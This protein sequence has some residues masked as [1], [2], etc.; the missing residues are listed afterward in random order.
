M[1]KKILS[2]LIAILMIASITPLNAY[3]DGEIPHPTHPDV[4][5][6]TYWNFDMIIGHRYYTNQSEFKAFSKGVDY[7]SNLNMSRPYFAGDNFG[8]P[9]IDIYDYSPTVYEEFTINNTNERFNNDGA[10][11]NETI[12]QHY[13]FNIHN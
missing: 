1:I 3:D 5:I 12:L 2:I 10:R 11:W 6:N 7:L 13:I 4:I 9:H 8:T